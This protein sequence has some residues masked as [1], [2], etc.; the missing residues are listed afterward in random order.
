VP[1]ADEGAVRLISRMLAARARTLPRPRLT[2]PATH[3]AAS[4][5]QRAAH[6]AK[7]LATHPATLPAALIALC[8]SLAVLATP[9]AAFVEKV[10]ITKVGLQPREVSR[11]WEGDLK[12]NGLGKLEAEAN[13]P[14]TKFANN[15]GAPVMH[16]V[17]TYA[18]FWDPQDFYHGDWQGLIEGFLANLGHAG[19][20]LASVFAVDAQY[21][22][23]TNLPAASHSAFLGGYTDTT[24]YPGP[25]AGCVNPNRFEF[26]APLFEETTPVCL[27]D[28]EVQRELTNFVA[29]HNLHKGMETIF[30][31]LTPPGVSVCVSEGHCS[32]FKGTIAVIEKDEQEKATAESKHE[33]YIEPPEYKS[34]KNSFC[35]YH[36]AIGDGDANT[37]IYAAIPWTAGGE[38][39]NH[40]SAAD[41]APGYDCQ[42]GGFGPGTLPNGELQEKEKEKTATP[43]E[44]EEFY[45]KTK[46]EQRKQRE[47][48]AMGLENQHDQE[49]NQLAGKRSIDG[50]FDTGLADL[51]VNQI[52]VEQQNTVTDPLLNAWQD[53]AGNEVTDECRNF[54]APTTGGSLAAE[55]ETRAGT[56]Y[57]QSLSGK[58]YYLN[59]AFDLAALELPYPGVQCRTGIELE[60]QFSD[61]NPVNAGEI[62]GFNGM[63][64]DVT[65]NAGTAYSASGEAKPTYATYKWNFGDGSPEVTG[66]APG[67]PAENPPAT[68]CAE[69]W[70]SPCA[71]STFHS[72]QY[73]GIYT[74]TLTITDVGGNTAT[75]SKVITVAGPPPPAPTPTPTPTPSPSGGASPA[76]TPAASSPAPSPGSG[77]GST[78]PVL[79]GPIATAAAVS[80]SLKQVSRKGLVVHYNVNEQ[81][82][83][84]FEVLLAASTAHSL[85]IGGRAASELP[86]GTPQSLVIGQAL[87]VTTKGGHSS[88]RIKFSKRTA[89]HLRRAKTVTLMLRLKVRNAAKSPIFTTV[90]STVSLH[91]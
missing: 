2:S 86:A 5:R 83:G 84:R 21:T 34:Y 3:P 8:L 22:D 6:T 69:P 20:Q 54:F 46:E 18:I 32:E 19:T 37:I 33:T 80:S 71:A 82:A 44:E 41:N 56:L 9:A 59:S 88:V 75:T 13:L 29:Q 10:G 72:Y 70:L 68:L 49:P 53:P 87:L 60:P 42:D 81:V 91:R 35:S 57:N 65:L 48:E 11:Y 30:Y 64:S 73:G 26:G 47:A 85:G 31:V 39:D 63:Q 14:A 67:A 89:K 61:P 24:P 51:I 12:R 90:F 52:A 4:P 1:A 40:L 50:S 66:Y 25:E 15:E 43:K 79:P 76:A 7:Q 28:A 62:V 23:A 45:A 38:G 17:D 36:S 27:T 78:P 77:S 55:P 74:V 58:N 16:N